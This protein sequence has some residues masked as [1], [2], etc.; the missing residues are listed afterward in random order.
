MK[1]EQKQM[2][3]GVTFVSFHGSEMNIETGNK[4]ESSLHSDLVYILKK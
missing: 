1:T 3:L 4:N 2:K